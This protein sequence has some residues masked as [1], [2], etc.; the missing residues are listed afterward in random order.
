M[1][2]KK[3]VFLDR[4]GVILED[5]HYLVDIKDLEFIPRAI[6]ALKNIPEDYLKIIVSNQSGVGRGYFTINQLHLFNDKLLSELKKH[7][8]FINELYYCPHIPDENCECR[9]PK[10]GMFLKAKQQLGIDLSQSWMIGDKS[11]DIQA[12][13]KISAKTIQVHTG[14]SGKEPGSSKIEPDYYVESLF[15]AVE[16]INNES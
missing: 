10:T 15:Q 11:S 8:V 6:E 13:K 14:Y 9:K 7:G 3:A 12:G 2:N 1:K 16:I 4:D 5:K